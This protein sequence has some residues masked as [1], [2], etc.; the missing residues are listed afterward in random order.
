M[1][2]VTDSKSSVSPAS[3]RRRGQG[4]SAREQIIRMAAEGNLA[5][6]ID[7]YT[8]D[9]AV[10]IENEEKAK[11]IQQAL[12]AHKAKGGTPAVIEAVLAAMIEFDSQ[13]LFVC[14]SRI[15]EQMKAQTK[16][17]GYLAGPPSQVVEDEL[18]R[19]ARIQDRILVLAKSYGTVMHTL[20]IATPQA[21][22]AG[23]RRRLTGRV[24]PLH[25]VN[26]TGRN[27]QEAAGG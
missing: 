15:T 12:E 2:M 18:P 1:V 11:L 23:A 6:L 4:L 27:V 17:A 14:Q 25:P 8:S 19:L 24:V 5:G 22:A 10:F 16:Q 3:Q 9:L 21:A 26:D 20:A 7:A 13:F